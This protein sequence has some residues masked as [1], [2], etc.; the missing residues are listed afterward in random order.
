M[1]FRPK[2]SAF[3]EEFARARDGVCV[4]YRRQAIGELSSRWYLQPQHQ[5]GQQLVNASPARCTLAR[6]GELDSAVQLLPSNRTCA[7]RCAGVGV[8]LSLQLEARLG[9]CSRVQW[10]VEL[11]AL[12]SLFGKAETGFHRAWRASTMEL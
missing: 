2:L 4:C 8:H 10:V 3:S 5:A 1:T 6:D 12:V 11:Q 7:G 9:Y